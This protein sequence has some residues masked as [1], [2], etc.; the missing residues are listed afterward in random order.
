MRRADGVAVNQQTIGTD[1][2]PHIN[3]WADWQ[4]PGSQNC[5]P[6]A[7]GTCCADPE[8]DNLPPLRARK[9]EMELEAYHDED[10]MEDAARNNGITET[11]FRKV[12]AVVWNWLCG[13]ATMVH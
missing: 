9:G 7:P 4:R 11:E 8:S 13:G 6:R 3:R 5:I 12:A 10:D 1:K 2:P